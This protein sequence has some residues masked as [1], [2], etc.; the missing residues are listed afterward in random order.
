LGVRIPVDCGIVE[1]MASKSGRLLRSDEGGKMTDWYP[2]DPWQRFIC[3]RGKAYVRPT[4]TQVLPTDGED[5][6]YHQWTL[7]E[8]LVDEGHDLDDLT[9][10]QWP[11]GWV[12]G[13][14]RRGLLDSTAI[15]ER[16][17]FPLIAG[18]R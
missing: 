12:Y 7:F 5:G 11:A 4:D 6:I 18:P 1:R 17:R 10:T 13:K 15:H 9:G 14:A 16:K 2:E 8:E 3:Y